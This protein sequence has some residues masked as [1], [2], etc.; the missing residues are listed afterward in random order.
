MIELFD[1]VV[2]VMVLYSMRVDCD[3][4]VSRAGIN[5]LGN[6]VMVEQLLCTELIG[7]MG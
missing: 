1:T 5:A 3:V 6:R 4:I 7:E 2:L